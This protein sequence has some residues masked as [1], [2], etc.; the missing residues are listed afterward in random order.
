[1]E[2]LVRHLETLYVVVEKELIRMWAQSQ[3]IVF[4]ALG[5]NPHLDEIAGKDVAFEQ[6]LVILLQAIQRFGEASRHIGHLLLLFRRQ[7]VDVLVE[8][9]ARL[10]LVLD[11][12][13][14]SH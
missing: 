1:M 4:F 8:W 12:I 13:Q 10:D 3:R 11:P 14:A 9:F 2:A 5:R 6:E 7:L